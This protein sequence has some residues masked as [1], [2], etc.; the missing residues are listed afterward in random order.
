MA[1]PKTVGVPF[2]VIG[3]AFI[4]LGAGQRP[5]FLAI[6]LVFLVL[7]VVVMARQRRSSS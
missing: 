6:G 7:G 5:A 4:A 2:L 1:V 3:L